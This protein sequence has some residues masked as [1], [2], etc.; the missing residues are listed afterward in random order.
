MDFDHDGHLDLVAS[1]RV[2]SSDVTGCAL[3]RPGAGDGT[4]SGG[5]PLVYTGRMGSTPF[6]PRRSFVFE[7]L[8]ADGRP[9]LVLT[10]PA[11]G[12][13]RVVRSR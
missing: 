10:A 3:V 9:E 5:P 2:T 8:D 4:F 1:A 12:V 13:V 11:D 7:D 6:A